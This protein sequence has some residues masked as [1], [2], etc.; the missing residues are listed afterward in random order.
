LLVKVGAGWAMLPS[1]P[2]WIGNLSRQVPLAG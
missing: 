2:L 1:D